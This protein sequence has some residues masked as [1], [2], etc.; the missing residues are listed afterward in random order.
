MTATLITVLQKAADLDLK[1]GFKPP[2]T[3]TMEAA[4]RWPR[5]FAQILPDYKPRLLALLG[6]PFVMVYSELLNE[7]VFFCEDETTK[8]ALLEAGADEW[9]IYTRDELRILVAQNRAKPFL[10]DELCKLHEIKR[11]FSARISHEP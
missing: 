2:D 1:L 8:A 9:S 7:T 6:L 11:T 4:K 5:Q 10:P 3:L